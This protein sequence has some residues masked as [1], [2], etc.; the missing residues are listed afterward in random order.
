MPSR[1]LSIRICA[2]IWLDFR[3]GFVDISAFLMPE[4]TCDWFHFILNIP[5]RFLTFDYIGLSTL[6][7]GIISGTIKEAELRPYFWPQGTIISQ[8][9]T[10][11]ANIRT[12]YH[13][14][15][16]V[17]DQAYSECHFRRHS[18]YHVP[19]CHACGFQSQCW[20]AAFLYDEFRYHARTRRHDHYAT[21][22]LENWISPQ[23]SSSSAFRY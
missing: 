12:R 14:R 13:A 5:Y 7:T 3:L 17:R 6:S 21:S 4:K 2:A 8:H 22:A 20:L 15:N 9:F 23:C 18:Y 16:A 1:L 19:F 11:I 10:L